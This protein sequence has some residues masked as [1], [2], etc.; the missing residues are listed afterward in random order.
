M[1]YREEV[2]DI[3]LA[4]LLLSLIFWIANGVFDPRLLLSYFLLV[5]LSF[6]VHELAHRQVAK[7]FGYVAFFKA[8]LEGLMLGLVFSFLGIIVVLPGAVVILP[9][10]STYFKPPWRIKEEM[11]IVALAGPLANIMISA[12]FLP[13]SSTPS[14]VRTLVFI[15]AWLALFNLLPIPPLDGSKVFWWS[16]KA[17]AVAFAIS[18]T[19]LLTPRFLL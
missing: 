2:T 7:K 3:A 5:V 18:L 16:K 17:W 15:N 11:G 10:F 8:S 1:F 6:F 14:F 12:I 4:I 9:A 19:T 13:F